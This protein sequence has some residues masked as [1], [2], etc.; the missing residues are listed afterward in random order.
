[1]NIRKGGGLVQWSKLNDLELNTNKCCILTFY[2]SKMYA[3][4]DYLIC[5]T[6]VSRVESMND[7]GVTF[8]SILNFVTHIDN[9][10]SKTMRSLGF[11]KRTTASFRNLDAIIVSLYK[12]V[13]TGCCEA[14]INVM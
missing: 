7:L 8:D 1:M 12:K 11:I 5:N 4:N 3:S 9:T 6:I 14:K 2:K 13:M 10:V